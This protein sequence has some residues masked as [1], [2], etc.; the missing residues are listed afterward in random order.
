MTLGGGCRNHLHF[1][2]IAPA[3]QAAPK[4]SPEICYPHLAINGRYF[5]SNT[6]LPRRLAF[7]VTNRASRNPYLYPVRRH[8]T[9]L[10]SSLSTVY[11]S[12]LFCFSP[13]IFSISLSLLEILRKLAYTSILSVKLSTSNCFSPFVDLLHPRSSS[14]SR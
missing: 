10:T 2:K 3:V 8:A 1:M 11:I 14:D 6:L 4:R 13:L 7:R 5:I 9:L 12:F